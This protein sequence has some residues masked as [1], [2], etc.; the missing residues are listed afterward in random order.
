MIDERRLWLAV[1][2]QTIIDLVHADPCRMEER[3]RLQHFAELWLR[4]NNHDVGSFL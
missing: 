4:S 2:E 1:L 3:P